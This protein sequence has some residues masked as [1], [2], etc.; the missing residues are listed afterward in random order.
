[1]AIKKSQLYSSIWKSCDELRGGMDASQYK[2]YVLVLLFI[3]YI[4][5][6]Y[7][8]VPYAPITIPEGSSF[9]DMVALKGKKTIGEDINTL[10]IAPIAKANQ[11]SE[12]P[13]F[14]NAEK[15]GS[16]PDQVK[17]LSNL[18]AIF[19]NP[20]LDFSKNRAEGDDILGDAYEYLMRHFAT[21]SGKSKGQ[22]YTPAEVSKVVA[23]VIGIADT[24]N[25]TPTIYDPTCGSGSLLLK[26]SDETEKNVKLYGQENDNATAALAR[27]NMILHDNPTAIIERE[28]TLATPKFKDGEQLKTF[29]YV[30]ANPPFSFKSWS[31]GVNDP[32]EFGRFENYGRPPAKNGDYA[33]LLHIIR[34]LKATG[35]GACILPHGVLFRGNA[36]AEIR[37]NIL[38]R[39]YIKGIIGLPANL[40]YGTGIPACIIVLDKENAETRKEIFIIDASKGFIKDGNKNRLRSQDIHKIVDVFNKQIE[41]PKYSRMVSLTEIEKNEYNLNIPRYI[42]SQEAEDMQDIEAHLRGG[43]PNADIETLQEYWDVYPN[44]KAALFSKA[45]R[46]GYS[47]LNISQDEIKNTIFSHPEFTQYSK[48]TELTFNAWKERSLKILNS[49]SIGIKPKEI[50]HQISED[51]L[52]AFSKTKL[53]NQY[54]IY[55]RLMEYWSENMQDDM[56][57]VASDGWK[58]ELTAVEGKKGELESDLVPKQLVINRYFKTE[59][60]AI[61]ELEANLS[62]ASQELEQLVE[63]HSGEDGFFTDF[64]KVNK[65]TV[66]LR[67]K[68][69]KNKAEDIEE[70]KIMEQYLSLQTQESEA[71]RS[72]KEAQK[73]LETQV[74]VKYKELTEA[75]IKTL[76]I[77]DKWMLTIEQAIQAEKDRISQR[78]TK[79]IKELAERYES[80]LPELVA[81]TEALTSK[82]EAHLN[83]MGY[84]WT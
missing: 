38:R 14:D 53:I 25:N 7:A 8:G 80:T 30:V 4:S 17:K 15:L 52:E 51:I 5:D 54:D 6:K 21:E 79:R 73:A 83:K 2:D 63:E 11:L 43:I 84:A 48:D 46:E 24:T 40:F 76:V 55:Q 49:L 42:D 62:S 82:V 68:E 31:N 59:K 34:S 81:E 20:A 44:L 29:D 60:Q 36:E 78:L 65:T 35:K 33:F 19:E 1:M 66:G 58:A 67:I 16:G 41:I 71:K 12:M 10:I 70:L 23:K 69:I 3:K 18:I 22:F 45:D 56:Y 28:N 47:A 64:D 75:D 77:D 74:I 32:D 57:I 72:I 39:G 26:V 13:D 37:T 61:E 9:K 27:M 50:I